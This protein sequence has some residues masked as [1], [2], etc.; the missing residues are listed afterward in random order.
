MGRT[1]GVVSARE[2]KKL[3]A[4]HLKNVK[5]QKT[6]SSAKTSSIFHPGKSFYASTHSSRPPPRPKSVTLTIPAKSLSKVTAQVADASGLSIPTHT[7]M[8]TAIM[9]AAGGDM[10]K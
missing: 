6:K 4:N 2:K 10:I 8:Q 9:G 1:E 5:K 3:L 7:V